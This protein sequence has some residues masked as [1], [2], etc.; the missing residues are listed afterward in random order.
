MEHPSYSSD[1]APNYFW[2]FSEI[3][4]LKGTNISG[5]KRHSRKCDRSENYSIRFPEM[6]P[7]VEVS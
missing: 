6:F 3:V 1:L 5:Y 2:Q 4:C 7:K